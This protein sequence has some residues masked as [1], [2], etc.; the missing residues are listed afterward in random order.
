MVFYVFQIADNC[1][2]MRSKKA[3]E[4]R[5]ALATNQ[6]VAHEQQFIGSFPSL[7]DHRYH[8]VKGEVSWN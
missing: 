4:L 1:P 5:V 8:P 2:K 7:E 6:K 3:G